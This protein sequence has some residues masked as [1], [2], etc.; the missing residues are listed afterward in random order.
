MRIALIGYGIVGESIENALKSSVDCFLVDPKLSE[1]KIKDL[2]RV[3]LVFVSV[4]TPYN[5]KEDRFDSSILNQVISDL[6][7][8]DINCPVIIK[9]A[10]PPRV[11]KNYIDIHKN[12]DIVVSPEYLTEKNHLEDFIDSKVMVLGGNT[13]SCNKIID[14]FKNHTKINSNCVYGI[15]TSEEAALIKYMENSFL[16]TKNTF[17]NQYKQYY[18]RYFKV[19]NDDSKFNDLMKLFHLDT[20][21]GD[22]YFKK[23]DYT[24]PGHDG[25]IGYGGKCLPKDVKTIIQEG[26]NIGFDFD[27]LSRVDSYND[28][29][30][31]N[32]DWLTID[33]AIY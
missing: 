33:G 1:T 13:S 32:K 26:K 10:V 30:R 23:R 24:I 12:L 11:V 29:I 8:Y 6:A 5:L 3:E 18:D 4:P 22:V 14:F 2:N 25:D 27:L 28:K 19:N 16:A 31:K 17:L 15:C 21:M 20:R 9:S 7:S